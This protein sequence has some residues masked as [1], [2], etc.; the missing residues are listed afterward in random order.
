MVLWNGGE[1]FW[2]D[3]L[4]YNVKMWLFIFWVNL[5]FI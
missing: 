4:G 3:G 5:G 2:L 1:G